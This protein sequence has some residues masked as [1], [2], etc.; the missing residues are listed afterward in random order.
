[1]TQTLAL[2][3]LISLAAAPAAEPPVLKEGAPETAGV[4]VGRLGSISSR[5]GE[6]SDAEIWAGGVYLIARNGVVVTHRAW[7]WADAE[8]KIRFEPDTLCQLASVTK[9]V[10]AT[11]VM[12][13]VEAGKIGLDDPVAKYIPSFRRHPAVTIQHL[14]THTSGLPRD[15]PSRK[16]PPAM[17]QSWL[18]RRLPDIAEEAAKMDLLFPPGT[19][20]SYCNAGIATLGRVVEVV[21]GRPF[22]EFLKARLFDPMGMTSATFRPPAEAARRPAVLYDNRTGRRQLSYRF[23]P[24]F[25]I[26]N[27]A[28]NGGLFATARDMAAFVQMFLNEGRYNG[29]QIL[30]A[31]TVRRMLTNHT[32]Q[33]PQARGLGWGLQG[34]AVFTH[35]GSSGTY[36]WGDRKRGVV[37]ILFSQTAGPRVSAAH[38]EFFER[39]TAAVDPPRTTVSPQWPRHVVATGYHNMTAVAADFTGDGLPDV[40]VNGRRQPLLYAAPAWKEVVI[41]PGPMDGIH[42]EVMDVDGDGDLDYIGVRYSPGLIFWLERP[43]R[44]LED[45]WPYHL[46]D[47]QVNGIHGLLTGDVDGDKRLDLAATAAQPG[48]FADSLAWFKVPPN[49]RRAERWLRYIPADKDAPGLS[50]Y[51][52]LGD[53]NGDGR[54]DIASA[55]KI[56]NGGNWFAWWEAP[57]DPTRTGWK[58]HLIADRQEGATNILMADVNGDGRMDFVGSRGHGKGVVWFEAPGWKLH[59]IHPTITG[60]HSLAVGDIDRDGDLDVVTCAKHDFTAAWF[61]NDGKGNFKTHVIYPDQA[62]YDVRLVDMD[63]D[64]DLDVLIAGQE[65]RNVVWY[66]NRVARK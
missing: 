54:T 26:V 2:F 25:R 7:G 20:Y 16:Y 10:T 57:A 32:P 34:D 31:A 61:E 42:S 58:K 48:P 8:N 23:D 44:P 22:D 37:G 28:P 9:P 15:V 66:E 49:P 11:A 4:S 47:D 21:S 35:S 19:K 50:H 63:R 3:F 13:L 53:V 39:V 27:P 59:E 56:A 40:V 62:A 41:H 29:V 36:Y 33:L 65:S 64:G 45:P 1:M 17:H 6:W 14:L 52:G 55:A 51:V 24:A 5:I 46:V 38:R 43:A 60:P 12:L 18:S 30:A